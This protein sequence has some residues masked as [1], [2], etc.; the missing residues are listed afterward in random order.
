MV[1]FLQPFL[2]YVVGLLNCFYLFQ[3]IFS[4][5]GFALF[6]IEL[7]LLFF[8]FAYLLVFLLREYRLNPEFIINEYFFLTNVTSYGEL[9]QFDFLLMFQL[10][11][12]VNRNHQKLNQYW[13][14]VQVCN[15]NW[16]LYK[17]LNFVFFGC[18]FFIF[19]SKFLLFIIFIIA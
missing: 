15:F 2:K 18:N 6:K 9:L 4:Q 3:I 10:L 5:L 17:R 14:F 7:V 1:I 11:I 12:N 8:P 19:L 16:F 13:I